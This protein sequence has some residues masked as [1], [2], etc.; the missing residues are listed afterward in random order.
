MNGKRGLA[1]AM[2]FIGLTTA[3]AKA[4]SLV[5]YVSDMY[6][7]TAQEESRYREPS[8]NFTGSAQLGRYDVDYTHPGTDLSLGG[9]T[10]T[11]SMSLDRRVSHFTLGGDVSGQFIDTDAKTGDSDKVGKF[12]TRSYELGLSAAADVSKGTAVELSGGVTGEAIDF[13]IGQER[14]REDAPGYFA[15]LGLVSSRVGKKVRMLGARAYTAFSSLTIRDAP[16]GTPEFS[17]RD[18]GVDAAVI[19]ALRDAHVG[20]GAG[21]STESNDGYSFDPRTGCLFGKTNTLSAAVSAGMPIGRTDISIIAAILGMD[22]HGYEAR[23]TVG[24]G[25]LT[26]FAGVLSATTEQGDLAGPEKLKQSIAEFG[27]S[28]RY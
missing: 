20:L 27:A 15:R 28:Y 25:N 1:I 3:A 12:D 19:L 14:Q 6:H 23:A 13:T 26:I 7:K 16:Q 8:T 24:I 10:G 18:S 22:K 17:R 2:A 4:D 9:L 21:Y 5:G 11:A